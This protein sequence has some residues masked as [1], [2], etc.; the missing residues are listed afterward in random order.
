MDWIEEFNEITPY[1]ADQD[2]YYVSLYVTARKYLEREPATRLC[3]RLLRENGRKSFDPL[4]YLD[5]RPIDEE[6][7]ST[8]HIL[9][10]TKETL[11]PIVRKTTSALAFYWIDTLIFL[12]G[13]QFPNKEQQIE[14]YKIIYRTLIDNDVL[15]KEQ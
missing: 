10:E 15:K 7:D 11:R 2:E 1:S 6:S 12:L 8:L 3:A 9:S 14:V 5:A 13:K 4:V